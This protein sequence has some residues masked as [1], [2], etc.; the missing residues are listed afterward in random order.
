MSNTDPNHQH[1]EHTAYIHDDGFP[2]ILNIT[3]PIITAKLAGI[4]LLSD[5]R[6]K[7]GYLVERAPFDPCVAEK[8]EV[9]PFQLRVK[10]G[11]QTG[12]VSGAV[13]II[14]EQAGNQVV[15]TGLHTPP[16]AHRALHV[17]AGRHYFSAAHLHD[18]LRLMAWCRLN[19]M[20]LHISEE[21]AYRLESKSHPEVTD[22]AHLTHAEITQLCAHAS[23][24]GI[25][26]VPGFDMPG[27][28]GGVLRAHPWAR[29]QGNNGKTYDGALDI[30]NPQACQLVWDLLDEVCD[31]FA[32]DEVTIGGDEFL[33]FGEG[34]PSLQTAAQERFG[35]NAGENDV[36]IEFINLTIARLRRRGVRAGVYNDGVRTHRQV[37]LDIDALVHYWTRWGA[38]MACPASLDIAGYQLVNWDGESCYFVLKTGQMQQV[39]TFESVWE[40][41]DPY[42]F[43]DK[44]G[45]YRNENTLGACF[46][47][48]CDHPD[49]LSSSEI[50]EQVTQPL[51]A[52]G[53]I[54]WPLGRHRNAEST[55][56]GLRA[57]TSGK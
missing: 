41:F 21:H 8:N 18:L 26:I 46:S 51:A 7:S 13:Q 27:H 53:T 25:R 4:E 42:T 2:T 24:L 20:N 17:D 3:N 49:A 37:D 40:K 15:T 35:Y 16:L 44:A 5:E 29:L 19:V 30:L 36:W 34:V 12:I 55:R 47:I 57:F 52:F 22:P 9:L 50:L 56:A 33:D 38:H 39:P 1:L 23:D 6:Y 31:C 14:R 48:W 28:L 54:C 43:P 11:S 45:T 32:S 10:A